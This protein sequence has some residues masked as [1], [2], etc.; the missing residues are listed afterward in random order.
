L[1]VA[2]II[3]SSQNYKKTEADEGFI[4]QNIPV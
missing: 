4:S 3:Y 2:K 1:E